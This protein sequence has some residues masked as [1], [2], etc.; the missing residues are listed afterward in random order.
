MT[1][2]IFG[3]MPAYKDAADNK[4]EGASAD[5]I[6]VDKGSAYAVHRYEVIR[7]PEQLQYEDIYDAIFAANHFGYRMEGHTMVV[8]TD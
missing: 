3:T 5:I 8:Y 6:L 4:G 7:K 1:Y 2:T